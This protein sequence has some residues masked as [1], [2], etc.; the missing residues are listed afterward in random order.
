MHFQG[1]EAAGPS[2]L[3]AAHREKNQNGSGVVVPGGRAGLVRPACPLPW[4]GVF[5]EVVILD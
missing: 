4:E 2:H 3:A 5:P 1:A